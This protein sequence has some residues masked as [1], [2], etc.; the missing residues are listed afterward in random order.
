MDR[1]DRRLFEELAAELQQAQPVRDKDAEAD[2]L[3]S[4]R[5]AAQPD[6]VYL[7]TQA[8]LLQ[9]EALKN[10]QQRIADLEAQQ[11]RQA[12]PRGGLFS[13]LFGGAPQ[14]G[15]RRTPYY[16]PY[17]Q[18]PGYGAGGSS[19]LGQAA[20]TAVGV[21]GGMLLF[22]GLTDLFDGGVG[23]TQAFEQGYDQGYDQ[24]FDQGQDAG[25][26]ADDADYGNDYNTDFDGG[27]DFGG[28]DW[29]V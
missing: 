19:F 4:Q 26:G 27:G 14:Y 25:T 5:I 16:Q 29:G 28:G 24:G 21:A 22:E 11:A 1:N 15:G 6:S 8:V 13:G 12:R 2:A 20:S 3:I 23:D 17:Y 10:A 7:L 9:Q 18:Q